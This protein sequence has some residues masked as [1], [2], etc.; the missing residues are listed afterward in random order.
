MRDLHISE[1]VAV[2]GVSLYVLGFGF[3]W[4][5]FRVYV[6]CLPSNSILYTISPLLFAPM[7]EAS[8]FTNYLMLI[9]IFTIVLDVWKGTSE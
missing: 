6:R 5:I 7:G 1:S 2:L 8:C 9:L 4:V 3:G